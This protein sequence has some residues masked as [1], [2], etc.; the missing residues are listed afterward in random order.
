MDRVL[1]T[2]E[3]LQCTITTVTGVVQAQEVANTAWK[4]E[5]YT[6][7]AMVEAIIPLTSIRILDLPSKG[8]TTTMICG[9]LPAWC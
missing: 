4:M 2:M 8:T 1:T 5:V 7:A 3:T 6:V 9:D